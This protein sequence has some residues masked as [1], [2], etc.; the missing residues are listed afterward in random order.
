MIDYILNE[1]YITTNPPR[2]LIQKLV[3]LAEHEWCSFDKIPK[4]GLLPY[5]DIEAELLGITFND[6]NELLMIFIT[7]YP[8]G[9][10]LIKELAKYYKF[11]FKLNYYSVF[12][13][14][15]GVFEYN[16]VLDKETAIKTNRWEY[17]GLVSYD[18]NT[19]SYTYEN[20][21]FKWKEELMDYLFNQKA[22]DEKLDIVLGNKVFS[23]DDSLP[24]PKGRR[25]ILQRI[26]YYIRLFFIKTKYGLKNKLSHD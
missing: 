25:S 3:M 9:G 26:Y 22:R 15:Q 16:H 5:R 6:S 2:E 19:N 1:L 14:C 21:T 11:S 12:T 10:S 20:N 18:S 4:V 24:S 23:F 7:D 13:L 8:N 17:Q